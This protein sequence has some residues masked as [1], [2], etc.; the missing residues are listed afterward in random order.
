MSMPDSKI[1]YRQVLATYGYMLLWISLS[2]SVIM[3]NKYILSY[4][5]FP[6]PIALTCLHM[7][8]CSILAWLCVK[9]GLCEAVSVSYD[10]YLR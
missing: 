10:T 9:T 2:A 8:F 1:A 7:G 6:F 4:S 5:G 3:L